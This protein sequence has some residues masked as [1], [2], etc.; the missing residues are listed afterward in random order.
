MARSRRYGGRDDRTSEVEGAKK[1]WRGAN[2]EMDSSDMADWI[3]CRLPIQAL[4]IG[5]V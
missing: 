5:T 4:R 3:Q 1:R 2:Y